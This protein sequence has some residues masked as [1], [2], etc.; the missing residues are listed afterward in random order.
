MA[1]GKKGA[2]PQVVTENFPTCREDLMNVAID[3]FAKRGF[4]GTSIRNIA[5]ALNVS[6]SNIYHYFG[7]K[8][9]LWLAILEH[10]VKELPKQLAVAVRDAGDDPVARFRAL[11]KAHL[12]LSARHHR[13]SQIFFIDQS[14]LSPEGMKVNR[15]IQKGVL[16][17]Y[18]KELNALKQAG[19]VHS[20]NIK[21]LSFNVLALVNWYLRW[22]RE[23]GPLPA[24]KV[25]QYIIDFAMCGVLGTPNHGTEDR[26]C[27]MSPGGNDATWPSPST[28]IPAVP[29]PT[30]SSPTEA[31]GAPSRRQRRLTT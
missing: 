2:T 13:E 10:S 9:G 28:S 5:D 6:V 17:I 15:K 19:K 16:D 8:D 4:K 27:P 25:H 21:I 29:S 31:T 30:D 20:D 26:G 7:N 14:M 11:L 12:E 3:L 23:D 18:V 24:E 1:A 22:Y